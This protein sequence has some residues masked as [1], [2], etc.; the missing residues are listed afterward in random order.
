MEQTCM[1]LRP[2]DLPTAR[3]VGQ[4]SQQLATDRA[5]RDCPAFR[6]RVRAA[7][8]EKLAAGPA[9][10]EDLT[11]HVAA[12]GIP[13][14]DGRSLGGIYGSMKRDGLIR[15]VPGVDVPRKR[16]HGTGGGRMWER[17]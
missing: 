3:A 12:S 11:D 14:A 10:G 6:E 8:L 9:S 15:I 17:C 13:F 2:P 16:G 4:V 1:D 5:E 7:V